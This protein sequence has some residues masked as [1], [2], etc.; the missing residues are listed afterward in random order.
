MGTCCAH[1]EPTVKSGPDEVWHPSTLLVVMETC[2]A[3]RYPL[4]MVVWIAI[5]C[6][7]A[8]DAEHGQRGFGQREIAEQAGV[9]RST[10]SKSIDFL[11]AHNLLKIVG[12]EQVSGN[13]PRGFKPRPIYQID[14]HDLEQRSTSPS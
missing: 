12:H 10:V 8:L 4:A 7:L 5:T 3:H 6:L 9:S 1:H 13:H 14:M 2:R 11:V